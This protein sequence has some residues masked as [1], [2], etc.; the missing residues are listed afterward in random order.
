MSMTSSLEWREH[1]L[2]QILGHK[3]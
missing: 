1:N 2:C 3:Q